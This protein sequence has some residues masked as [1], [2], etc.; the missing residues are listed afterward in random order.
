MIITYESV[1]AMNASSPTNNTKGEVVGDPSQYLY[2]ATTL[3]W[4][5]ISAAMATS[6][7]TSPDTLE[8]TGFFLSTTDTG[9]IELPAYTNPTGGD[10]EVTKC[11]SVSL[12]CS[13]S[14]AAPKGALFSYVD[15]LGSTVSPPVRGLQ[16]T[17]DTG[18]L[19]VALTLLGDSTIAEYP[20]AGVGFDFIL[21]ED[22]DVPD[23]PV[24]DVSSYTGFTVTYKSDAPLKLQ[25]KDRKSKDGAAWFSTLPISATKVT[26]ALVW[27]DFAQP[28]W[29]QVLAHVRYLPQN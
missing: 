13:V 12:L 16:P 8:S 18:E 28:E 19:T 24:V 3:S 27:A 29:R 5:K 15:D 2:N 6:A 21:S 9:V 1:E 10:V 11:N 14:D 7:A 4:G 20:Y 22:L 25:L 17:L 26:T 23:K